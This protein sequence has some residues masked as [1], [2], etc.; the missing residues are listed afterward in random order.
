MDR[1]LFS[2][3]V[4]L[5]IFE[6]CSAFLCFAENSVLE[7]I[8]FSASIKTEAGVGLWYTENSG[9]FTI[10]TLTAQGELKGYFGPSSFFADGR[11][12]F[13]ATE[14]DKQ[15][16]EVFSAKIKELFYTYDGSWWALKIGRQI[17]TWGA[18]DG[19]AVT[20]VL[21]PNDYTCLSSEKISDQKIGLD[22]LKLSFNNSFFILDMYY[23]PFFTPSKLPLNEKSLMSKVFFKEIYEKGL[24]IGKLE[25][26]GLNLKNSEY[27]ARL[28]FFFPF[29]DFSFYGFYGF[30]DLPVQ[31]VCV[32]G[33]NYVLCGE[34][35]H[36]GMAGFDTSIP[37][38]DFTFRFEGAVFPEKCFSTFTE[39]NYERHTEAVWL[40]GLDWIKGDWT[41]SSQYY[42]DYIFG[43]LEDIDKKRY[44]HSVTMNVVRSFF[45]GNL[46]LEIAVLLGLNDFDSFVQ[47]QIDY[48]VTDNMRITLSALIYNEGPS[49]PG[50]YGKYK[51]LS[52]II[53]SGKFTF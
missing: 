26:P 37:I 5:A 38:K 50:T 20:N 10:G 28:A 52:S 16:P 31:K 53:I 39:K 41:V 15:D 51:D 35:K 14:L 40:G 45:C 44:E 27:A 25:K 18:A 34:Y 23:I 49:N 12:S 8:D 42:A 4:F 17:S 33:E 29:A 13:D 36:L 47:P 43:N 48:A 7:N 6:F 19:L 22:A 3:F 32:Q 11:L 24:Q 21:C 30:D 1:K 9:D 2:R 46:E